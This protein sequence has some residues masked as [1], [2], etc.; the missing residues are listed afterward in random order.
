M[1]RSRP[2]RRQ[3]ARWGTRSLV[4]ALLLAPMAMVANV[5]P[6]VNGQAATPTAISPQP[7]PVSPQ[8]TPPPAPPAPH[9]GR[10]FFETSFRIDHDPFWSYFNSMGGVETFG[11][12]VSR[13]FP[14]LGCTTQFFQRQLMQQCGAGAPVRT[15]NLLDPDLMPYNRINFS[16]FPAHDEQVAEGAPPP[17]TANY[18]QAVLDYIRA[19]APD[20]FQGLAVNFFSTFV[21]TVPGSDPQSDPNFAALTNLEIWGFPTSNPAF[22]P[23]NH[24]FVYQRFQRG[25]MHHDQSSGVTQGI[26]LSDYFKSIITGTNLPTDLAAQAA[27]SRFF[28]QYCP[29]AAQWVCRPG[30]LPGTDLTFAFE[31]Q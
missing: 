3:T 18:G 6:Q 5:A 30:V 15:M 23:A 13:T 16:T 12:P 19:I 31:L 9:D 7:T 4:L 25:I 24:S 29:G 8:P 27:G 1:Q 14:F 2:G 11:F 28:R 17:G 26:L 21:T 10:Y 22:D 20:V